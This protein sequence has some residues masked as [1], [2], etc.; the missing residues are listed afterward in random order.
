MTGGHQTAPFLQRW[1]RLAAGA[2][3]LAAHRH[4]LLRLMLAHESSANALALALHAAN[5][6][7]DRL[8]RRR[9]RLML[10]DALVPVLAGLPCP[11][12][13]IWS[14][15]ASLG[16][17]H[18][19]TNRCRAWMRPALLSLTMTLIGRIRLLYRSADSK[20]GG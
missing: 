8:R 20:L 13:V 1:D 7:R 10:S 6:E 11:L 4:N 16:G 5:A 12:H 18:R 14:A 15:V 17:Q 9:R 19:L 2:E 3:R